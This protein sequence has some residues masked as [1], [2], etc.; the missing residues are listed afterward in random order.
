MPVDPQ[1]QTLL[2]ALEE[3]GGAKFVEMSA[4]DARTWFNAFRRP[5]DVPIGAVE[6]RHIPGPG[7]DIP[8]RL[9]TP[10]NAGAGSLPVLVYFHGGGWVVGDLDSHDVVCRSLANASGCKIV[11]VDYRLAPEH[12]WPAAPDDC[13]AAV[14]WVVAHAAELGV[15]AGRLAVGGDS[16]GGN[17]AAAVTLRA[18]AANGPNIAFQ[19]LIYPAVDATMSLDSIESNGYSYFLE[20]AG[21]EWFYDHYLSHPADAKNPDVSPLFADDLSGLPPAYVVTA[22]YDPLRDEGR[23]YA[24][25]LQAAGVPVEYINYP[26]MIHGFFGF[27]AVVDVSG[28]AVRL[29]GEAVAKALK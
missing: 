19:L 23:A 5:F 18:R 2:N 9:F 7:G 25:K 13:L 29:A 15:D 14:Q 6:N 16:A 1:V 8:V 17:L 24:D 28:E 4:I 22:E 21:M 20:K 26:T 3:A 10:V 11:S 27:Q 12:P